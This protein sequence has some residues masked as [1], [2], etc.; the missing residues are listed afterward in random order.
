MELINNIR[1]NFC[2]VWYQ[3]NTWSERVKNNYFFL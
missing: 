3:K 1:E 2:L